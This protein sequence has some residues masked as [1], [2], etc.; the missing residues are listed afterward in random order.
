M[1]LKQQGKIPPKTKA[2][3]GL[4]S[5]ERKWLFRFAYPNIPEAARKL[6]IGVASVQNLM[7]PN[8]R[9]TKQ[10]IDK[11]RRRIQELQ[12]ESTEDDNKVG[13]IHKDLSNKSL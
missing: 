6:G 12:E 1:S 10:F 11:V 2:I 9:S 13:A 5:S 3:Y 8:S 7:D 4:E